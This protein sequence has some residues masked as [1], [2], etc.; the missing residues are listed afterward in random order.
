MY[1]KRQC[2]FILISVFIFSVLCFS[3]TPKLDIV[4]P[5]EGTTIVRSSTFIYGNIYPLEAELSINGQEVAVHSGGGFLAYLKIDAQ[6]TDKKYVFKCKAINN[7]DI[8]THEQKV[9]LYPLPF[10]YP[11][12]GLNLSQ[13]SD[14]KDNVILLNKGSTYKLSAAF[15]KNLQVSYSLLDEYNDFIYEDIQMNELE[16]GIYSSD[17]LIGTNDKFKKANIRFKI[18]EGAGEII[19]KE[20][21]SVTI[22]PKNQVRFKEVLFSI[23]NNEIICEN[24]SDFLDA[25]IFFKKGRYFKFLFQKVNVNEVSYSF[26]NEDGEAYYNDKLMVPHELVDGLFFSEFYISAKDEFQ[27]SK[28]KFQYKDLKGNLYEKIVTSISV[29]AD[30]EIS[31]FMDSNRYRISFKLSDKYAYFEN[32]K[33]FPDGN[34]LLNKEEAL[35]IVIKSTENCQV[36]YS[37]LD[38]KGNYYYK[39][40]VMQ[41]DGL[42]AGLYRAELFIG[43]RDTFQEANLEFEFIYPDGRIIHK[44]AKGIKISCEPKAPFKKLLFNVIE[45]KIKMKNKTDYNDGKIIL[46][47][48]SVYRIELFKEGI[49]NVNYTILNS[50]SDIYYDKIP[51]KESSVIKGLFNSDLSIGLEDNFQEARIKFEYKDSDKELNEE[52]VK[53]IRFRCFED[54]SENSGYIAKK[55]ICQEGIIIDNRSMHPKKDMVVQVGDIIDFQ[56]KGSSN[57]HVTYSIYDDNDNILYKDL[58]MFDANKDIDNKT[59]GIYTSAFVVSNKDCFKD[60]KI[61]FKFKNRQGNILE[62][63]LK[64]RISVYDSPIPQVV[65]LTEEINRA[66]PEVKLAYLLFLPKGVRSLVTGKKKDYVRLK[67]SK[68]QDVWIPESN[69]KYLP[70]GI[71]NPKSIIPYISHKKKDNKSIISIGI[72]EKLPYKI[73]HIPESKEF[74]IKIYNAFSHADWVIMD[75]EDENIRTIR[76]DQ[77]EPGVFQLSIKLT[78][79]QL[80]GYDIRYEEKIG[81]KWKYHIRKNL[82]IELTHKKKNIKLKDLKICVDPGHSLA[83]G[84]VGPTRFAEKEANLLIALELKKM[85]E[86]AK[87]EV[88]M[89]RMDSNTNVGLMERREIAINNNCDLFI[90]IHNNGLPDGVNP[91]LNTGTSDLYYHP[92]SKILADTILESMVRN[93]K[94]PPYCMYRADICVCRMHQMPSVLVECIF[95]IIPEQEALLKTKGFQRKCAKGI[96]EG[97]KKFVESK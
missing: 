86:K 57:C 94:Y 61:K 81:R 89:T 16:K 39:N 66:R 12:T 67:L 5:P 40:L 44:K 83:D 2:F 11:E 10:S 84:V 96:L 14:F 42:I 68:N 29:H 6:D 85:L 54:I 45:D 50:T 64:A 8:L 55:I 46:N 82:V 22:K 28:I 27:N 41:E 26:I 47:K 15:K 13:K 74:R 9:I 75:T 51:M 80:W 65:E 69:V 3:E 76:W 59:K 49:Q 79:E 73:E 7:G 90:S 87:A 62:K 32:N 20:L 88:I 34:I 93:T 72:S 36:R 91:F 25:E 58:P 53:D 24:S 17:L 4:Y 38:D 30:T 63:E 92:Q 37:L 52:V 35:G 1:F 31:H 48:G 43:S 18:K 95:Q 56:V 19:E 33:Y 23:S 78:N 97:L 71:P 70:K 21:N 77:P 60:A